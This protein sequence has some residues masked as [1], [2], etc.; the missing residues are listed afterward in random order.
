MF[1]P[2]VLVLCVGGLFVWV[3]SRLTGNRPMSPPIPK[4]PP[5]SSV[6][7]YR[8]ISI[9]SV[10]STVFECLVSLR[11]GQF[12]D[13][14]VCFQPPCLLIGKVWEPVR[15][16]RHTH[17]ACRIHCTLESGQ[18]SRIAKINFS[19]TFDRVN[20]QGILYK[21]CSVGILEV[22]CFLY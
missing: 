10:L 20:H 22:L 18:E 4:G 16:L 6:A 8:P 3:F 21:L 9:I 1:W 11:L 7:N 13:A 17:C 15:H 14:V 12:M 19:A 2:H 5:S